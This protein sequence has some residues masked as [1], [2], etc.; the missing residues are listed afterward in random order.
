ML[1]VHAGVVVD[2]GEEVVSEWV[3]VGNDDS[4]IGLYRKARFCACRIVVSMTSAKE[5]RDLGRIDTQ[6]TGRGSQGSCAA[7]GM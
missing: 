2:C 6:N 7:G 1:A 5:N 3:C 4:E